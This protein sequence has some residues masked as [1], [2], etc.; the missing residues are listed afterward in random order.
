MAR[1]YLSKF[2]AQCMRHRPVVFAAQ[3]S[4]GTY[5]DVML[6]CC[7]R[8][9]MQSLLT[10]AHQTTVNRKNHSRAGTFF[11]Y[12]ILICPVKEKSLRIRSENDWSHNSR[13][14]EEKKRQTKKSMSA[15]RTHNYA[16]AAL[17]PILMNCN[18]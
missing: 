3:K 17:P 12:L 4:R 1:N 9:G 8:T 7:A 6:V 16:L 11:S 14:L 2:C 15:H 10:P 5:A 18:I 13:V